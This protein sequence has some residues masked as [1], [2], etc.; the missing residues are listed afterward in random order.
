MRE[1][2]IGDQVMVNHSNYTNYK[3]SGRVIYISSDKILLK[4]QI[5][6]TELTIP[7]KY[8]K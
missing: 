2:K 8:V 7:T 4:M 5:G 3:Q 1:I 6:S